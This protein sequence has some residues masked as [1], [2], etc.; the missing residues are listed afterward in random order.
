VPSESALR[1]IAHLPSAFVHLEAL[2]VGNV[3]GEAVQRE[4]EDYKV[5]NRYCRAYSMMDGLG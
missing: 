1:L 3:E 2:L 4:T 5:G